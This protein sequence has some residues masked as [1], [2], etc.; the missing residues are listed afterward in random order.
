MKTGTIIRALIKEKKAL[1]LKIIRCH[2]N[3]PEIK[4]SEVIEI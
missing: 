4:S 2:Y 3:F 1:V